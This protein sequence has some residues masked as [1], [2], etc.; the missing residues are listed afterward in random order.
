MQVNSTQSLFERAS[1]S[2]KSAAQTLA[3][4]IEANAD[5]L[6]ATLRFYV[7]R[8]GLVESAQIPD[9]AL[10]LMSQVVVE[11]LAHADHFDTTRSPMAWLLGIAANLL[12]RKRVEKAKQYE[13]EPFVRD[14]RNVR[15]LEPTLSDDELFDLVATLRV[16]NWEQDVEARERAEAMLRL[17]SAED[18]QVLRLAILHELNGEMLARELRIKPGAARVRLHRALDHLREEWIRRELKR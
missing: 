13:R 11:A 16:E 8:A 4:F 3:Q 18:Q 15:Q 2:H 17:V 10:E 9:T 12:K 1:A 6:L 5:A 7:W 14:L